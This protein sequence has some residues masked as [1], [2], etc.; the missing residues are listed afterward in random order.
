MGR[1]I[2][3]SKLRGPFFKQTWAHIIATSGYLQGNPANDRIVH[4]ALLLGLRPKNEQKHDPAFTLLRGV[5]LEVITNWH[6]S[7][8]ASPEVASHL[9]PETD[10][11]IASRLFSRMRRLL[12]LPNVKEKTLFKEK[13]LEQE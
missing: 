11:E 4:R 3:I 5:L 6:L 1:S 2:E 10:S 12:E 9:A 7:K 8:L 13:T